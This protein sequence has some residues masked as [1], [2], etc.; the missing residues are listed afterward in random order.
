MAARAP[1]GSPAAGPSSYPSPGPNYPSSPY[2]LSQP[3][4]GSRRRTVFPQPAIQSEPGFYSAAISSVGGFPPS[5]FPP[6]QGQSYVSSPASAYPTTQSVHPTSRIPP[7]LQPGNRDRR[8]SMNNLRQNSGDLFFQGP[9]PF[10]MP[11]IPKPHSPPRHAPRQHHQHPPPPQL[12]HSQSS[13][14]PPI[15]VKPYHSPPVPPKPYAF[16]DDAPS[17]IPLYPQPIHNSHSQRP[18]E[19]QT[20]PISTA[21]LQR[22]PFYGIDHD[23]PPPPR[24][25]RPLSREQDDPELKKALELST[26]SA[27]ETARKRQE[28]L[29]REDE[30][31][32]RAVQESLRLN[33][34]GFT[35]PIPEHLA[36]PEVPVQM[37]MPSTSEPSS[38]SYDSFPS[39][40][41]SEPPRSYYSETPSNAF[42]SSPPTAG[43]QISEDER[44]ARQLVEEEEQRSRT[45]ASSHPPS[46]MSSPVPSMQHAAPVSASPQPM[47][48][49][50]LSPHPG[51]PAGDTPPMYNDV[52]SSAIAASPSAAPNK[53]PSLLSAAPPISATPSSSSPSSASRPASG[54]GR[55]SSAQAVSPAVSPSKPPDARSGRSGSL[56]SSHS[57]PAVPTQT[58]SAPPSLAG[59]EK[60]TL[61]V[62]G[63]SAS[64][65]S[66]HSLSIVD[67]EDETNGRARA[68]SGAA[69]S[70]ATASPA[71]SANQYIDQE[72]LQGISLGFNPPV[73]RPNMAPMQGAIPNVVALP[74]GRCPPFHLKAP[75]WRDLLKLMARLSNTRLEPTI[76]AMAL[77]KTEMRVR[78]VV[79]FV[80]VHQNTSDW[81]VILYMTIDQPV[82][83]NHPQRFKYKN[84]DPNT[85]PFSYT[86]SATPAYLREGA[87]API[88][89]WY[90]I[91]ATSGLPYPKLPITFP[92][93]ATYLLDALEDSRR[94]SHD[95]SGGMRR[96]AKLVETCY[97][98]DRA[99]D[100][101]GRE[102]GVSGWVRGLIGRERQRSRDRNEHTYDVV[103]PF[104]PDEWGG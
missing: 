85:L 37:P 21:D 62:N 71:S 84:G 67:E 33:A 97:P 16:L 9:T 76:E 74:Y 52:V 13:P 8:P 93:L 7:M 2:P 28:T 80:K 51:T 88:S 89:K 20:A 53:S 68:S 49:S 77:V 3:V 69:A 78:V 24:P 48:S 15:P 11:H 102:K 31:I 18:L 59:H 45:S 94:T 40:F 91:P 42:T 87:D 34:S 12:R 46:V 65:A 103:T 29:H 36:V 47:P 72:L 70:T 41:S 100:R 23:S 17:T 35:M 79:N 22:S 1:W 66:A 58:Q 19:V 25:P 75:S 6:S 4:N 44:L 99:E 50:L 10:P 26:Q 90:S 5:P 61:S 56:D 101:S 73:I 57:A 60:I 32:A 54:L 14:A 39:A 95:G 98:T 92:D 55:S 27:L 43:S 82:P 86:H 96:L 64:S 30:E 81:H 38:S 63:T 104:V 83:Q